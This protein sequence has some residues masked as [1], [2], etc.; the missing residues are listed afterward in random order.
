MQLTYGVSPAVPFS[1]ASPGGI[2]RRYGR[3]EEGPVMRCWLS[4]KNKSGNA[5][6]R[7]SLMQC[8][9]SAVTATQLRMCC[10]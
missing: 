1:V 4:S 9:H 3:E 6:R 7:A 2:G 5:S 8:R 10:S